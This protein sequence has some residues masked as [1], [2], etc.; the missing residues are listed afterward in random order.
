MTS[1]STSECLRFRDMDEAETQVAKRARVCSS[2]EVV[3]DERRLR[4]MESTV[5][6]IERRTMYHGIS[7]VEVVRQLIEVWE[8]FEP[9]EDLTRPL[10]LMRDILINYRMGLSLRYKNMSP[11]ERHK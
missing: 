3:V 9:I 5:S 2:K 1:L 11:L 8:T 7:P 6:C 10:G 4:E